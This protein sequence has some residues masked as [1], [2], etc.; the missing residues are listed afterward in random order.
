M[1][2]VN[3]GSTEP[4]ALIK[5]TFEPEGEPVGTLAMVG[6]GIMY[7]AGGLALKPADPVHAAMK[8]DMSG[9]GAIM[10][11]MA[12]LGRLGCQTA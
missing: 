9:A 4:P 11:A 10:G 1:L 6:K 8:N 2:G 3:A 5:L 7:D 12:N